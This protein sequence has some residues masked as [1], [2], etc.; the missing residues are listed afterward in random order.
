M[1]SLFEGN[2]LWNSEI[3]IGEDTLK[4]QNDEEG[5]KKAINIDEV[6]DKNKV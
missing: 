2:V 3:V 4:M 5:K 6:N 1:V